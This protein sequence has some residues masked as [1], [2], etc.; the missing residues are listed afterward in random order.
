MLFKKK[1]KIEENVLPPPPPPYTPIEYKWNIKTI[2]LGFFLGLEGV[3]N[4]LIHEKTR[5]KL[6]RDIFLF[7]SISL[8]IYVLGYLISIPFH[9]LKIFKLFGF[10]NA[11]FLAET[12]EKILFWIIRIYP[13]AILLIIRYIYPKYLDDLFFES[14]KGYPIMNEKGQVPSRELLVA[15]N[16]AQQLSTRKP[17]RS[18]I[19]LCINYV[20]RLSKKLVKGSIIY[21]LIS[22]PIIGKLILPGMLV[23]AISQIFPFNFSCGIGVL[24]AIFPY[25]KKLVTAFLFNC[26]FGI[27]TMNREVLE[28]YFCRVKM[29][30]QEKIAWFNI[31]EPLLFGFM[32]LFYILFLQPWYGPLFF[33]IAQGAIPTLLVEI[34]KYHRPELK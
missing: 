8:T 15:L 3:K 22:L 9:L 20:K 6:L 13:Q 7:L 10:S 33:A 16:Y 30:S 12:M 31:Y 17:S 4:T 24:T 25:V 28:P 32:S 18:Y 27:R 34:F 11:G 21:I 5:N 14:F 2:F 26:I 29:T 1:S 19:K 23:M